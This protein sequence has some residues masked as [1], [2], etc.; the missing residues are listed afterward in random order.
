MSKAPCDTG[1]MN[2]KQRLS[3]G[4]PTTRSTLPPRHRLIARFGA[5]RLVR[6]PNGRHELIG[7]T[8]ADC[9]EAR[10]W[11]SLF[12][13][14]VVFSSAPSEPPAIFLAA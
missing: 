4:A 7:G 6:K 13:P 3:F 14:E 1:R 10:E 2:M 11:C 8:P 12:A 9:A 5:A